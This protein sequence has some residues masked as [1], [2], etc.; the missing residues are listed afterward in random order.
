MRTTSQYQ[1]IF[2]NMIVIFPD[3]GLEGPNVGQMKY[4]IN[5]IAPLTD[6]KYLIHDARLYQPKYSRYL[7]SAYS[8]A[9]KTGIIF[10]IILD[11]GVGGR[12]DPLMISVKGKWFFGLDNGV[13]KRIVCSDEEARVRKIQEILTKRSASC[14]GRDIFS[15]SAVKIFDGFFRIERLRLEQKSNNLIG[16][17]TKN[18]LFT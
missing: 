2:T 5:S 12:R 8:R 14:H 7:L 4:A 15:P 16:R 1:D 6:I 18:Q 13:F 17:I 3:F 9:L 10:V 11:P